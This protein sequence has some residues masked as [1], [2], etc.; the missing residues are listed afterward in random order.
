MVISI[1]GGEKMEDKTFEMLRDVQSEVSKL[2]GDIRS[3]NTLLES[4]VVHRID[5]LE[6]IITFLN[7]TVIGLVLKLAFDVII[8]TSTN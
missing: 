1:H 2:G 4:S 6:K 8:K 5:K 7:T 3:I